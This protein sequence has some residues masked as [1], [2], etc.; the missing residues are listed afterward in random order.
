M[1]D[2]GA[3]KLGGPVSAPAEAQEQME[4]NCRGDRDPVLRLLALI[5]GWG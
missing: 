4:G 2:S 5:Y 3:A 1:V